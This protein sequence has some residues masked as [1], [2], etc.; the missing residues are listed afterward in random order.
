MFSLWSSPNQSN[1]G[2]RLRKGATRDP[3]YLS[4]KENLRC[5]ICNDRS[6]HWWHTVLWDRWRLPILISSTSHIIWSI[7]VA[8]SI[9][10]SCLDHH[11]IQWVTIADFLFCFAF[12]NTYVIIMWLSTIEGP[13]F[14]TRLRVNYVK[15]IRSRVAISTVFATSE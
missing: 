14:H 9:I 5:T 11:L 10:S 1:L 15:I 6:W 8:V 7:W 13:S 2:V 4:W 3:M 12:P